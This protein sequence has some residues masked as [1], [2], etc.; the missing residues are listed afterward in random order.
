V[1][2]SGAEDVRVIVRQTEH[3]LSLS[4]Q[5]DG[6]GFDP[7]QERGMGLLGIQERVANLGGRFSLES[8]TGQGTELRVDLPVPIVE[9]A[10][11]AG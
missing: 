11:T 3:L 5:D 7:S 8:Q 2:H 9:R 10:R 6:K 1:Q 4:I